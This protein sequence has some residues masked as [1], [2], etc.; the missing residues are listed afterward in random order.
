MAQFYLPP[1]NEL[2]LP[3]LPSRKA[4]P[5]FDWCSLCLPTK[6][7]PGW[8]DL[9]SWLHT[10]TNIPHL[11]QLNYVVTA[12]VC[13]DT[14][15]H[16][17]HH[18]ALQRAELP[19]SAV[20]YLADDCQLTTTLAEDDFDHPPGTVLRR[21]VIQRLV[22]YCGDADVMF[23]HVWGSKNSH[24]TGWLDTIA[25]LHPR[26]NLP[27]HEPDSELTLLE[28][29]WLP[30]THLFGWETQRPVTRNV[31]T[32]SY[33]HLIIIIIIIIIISS[34]SSSSSWSQ[35]LLITR[36]DSTDSRTI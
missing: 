22:K 6:G 16:Q 33:H 2:Y 10:E 7:W 3:L 15:H 1:T 23:H 4:S 26:N 34:S 36:T 12:A 20:Q 25:G 18:N 19:G 17:H 28:L 35:Q 13:T 31:F 14:F 24:K 9:G 8:V 27:L 21:Q 32:Y 29:C 5:P 11:V 30:K